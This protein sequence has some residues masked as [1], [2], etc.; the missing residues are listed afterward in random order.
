MA[1]ESAIVEPASPLAPQPATVTGKTTTIDIRKRL[2]RSSTY[3][4]FGNLRQ[5]G[6]EGLVD[7]PILETGGHPIPEQEPLAGGRASLGAA[8]KTVY[9]RRVWL[10]CWTPIRTTLWPGDSPPE[11]RRNSSFEPPI[12]ST[13]RNWTYLPVTASSDFS[14]QFLPAKHQGGHRGGSL[15]NPSHRQ[16]LRIS[17]PRTERHWTYLPSHHLASGSRE[18]LLHPFGNGM[19]HVGASARFLDRKIGYTIWT[20]VARDRRTGAVLDAPLVITGTG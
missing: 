5:G 6:R 11:V 17:H 10:S 3:L 2:I 12:R 14:G 18:F 1:R 8:S 16:C 15:I 4:V 9:Q 20:L 19:G 7:Y 13:N